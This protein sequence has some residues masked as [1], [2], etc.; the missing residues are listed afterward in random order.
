MA[1]PVSREQKKAVPLR[2]PA[3][4]IEDVDAAAKREGVSRTAWLEE[5][6]RRRL[7]PSHT[8]PAGRSMAKAKL[9][10]ATQVQKAYTCPEH[11]GYNRGRCSV[12]SCYKDQK[13]LR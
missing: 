12:P 8:I 5:A 6:A 2:L 11:G 13:E 9:T 1:R 7:R 4:L 10:E 3:A